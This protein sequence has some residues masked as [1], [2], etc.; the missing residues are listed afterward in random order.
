MSTVRETYG[1]ACPNCGRDDW[2]V[3]GMGTLVLL[4][5]DGTE[6]AGDEVWG[7]DSPCG[8]TACD[9]W[10]IVKSFAIAEGGQP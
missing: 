3:V 7:I 4:L 6:S 8:C 5:P 2:I 10:D 1:L 9:H